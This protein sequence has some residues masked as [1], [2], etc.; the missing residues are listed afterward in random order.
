MARTRAG[1]GKDLASEQKQRGWDDQPRRTESFVRVLGEAVPD[2]GGALIH[3]AVEGIGGVEEIG[4]Q[5][6]RAEARA[7]A[8][9]SWSR[10]AIAA[11]PPARS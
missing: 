11:W 10:S 1:E 7:R 5:A 9:A 3:A 6:M 8:T 2:L 4:R